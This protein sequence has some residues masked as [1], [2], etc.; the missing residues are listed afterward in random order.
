MIE[1][2]NELVEI[3]RHYGKNPEY[4]LAGGGNT[5]Y[6]NQKHLWIKA[7]GTSLGAISLEGFVQMD[8][9]RLQALSEKQFSN[10]PLKRESEIIKELYECVAI[11]SD[12]RPSV[13]TSLHN[14]LDFK[15]V[16]HTHPTLVNGLMCGQNSKIATKELFG[17][18]VLFVEYCDPGFTLFK[19]VEKKISEYKNK[20]G[21]EPQIVFLE[22]HGVFVSANSI[23]EIKAL[24]ATIFETLKTKIEFPLPSPALLPCDLSDLT[25]ILAQKTKLIAM[26]FNSKLINE[27]VKNKESFNQANTAFSPDNIVYCKANYAYSE[28]SAEKLLNSVTAF[29]KKYSYLPKVIAIENL[30]L[31]CLEESA[32]SVKTVFDV[33]ID[34]LKISFYSRN[35]SGPR[36][37]N[38][39]QIEFIDNWEV[40]NYRRKI[41]KKD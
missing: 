36:F 32:I 29:E 33:Y 16:V 19:L 17:D 3:S 35:F 31:I 9:Q 13:E 37:L 28:A 11:P 4:V 5:S 27:F 30:G 14:L 20:F 22:N 1:E 18:A 26:E 25:K 39:S 41:A 21:K 15:F 40:E 24:Y 2:L 34:L 23:E 10:D 12:L 7:S 38:S 8:R 6:K